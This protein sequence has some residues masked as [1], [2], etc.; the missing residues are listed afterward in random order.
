[1][2]GFSVFYLWAENTKEI[3]LDGERVCKGQRYSDAQAALYAAISA[4]PLSVKWPAICYF[5][6]NHNPPSF[7]FEA[8][9]QEGE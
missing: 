2:S 3:W 5:N 1:M 7:H 4:L 8:G 9:N 6:T